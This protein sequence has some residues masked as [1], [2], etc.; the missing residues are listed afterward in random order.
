MLGTSQHLIADTEG[1]KKTKQTTTKSDGQSPKRK[2][3]RAWR[4]PGVVCPQGEEARD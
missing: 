2:V 1:E 3:T 4:Q